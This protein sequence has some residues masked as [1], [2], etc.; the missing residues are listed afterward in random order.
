MTSIHTYCLID[1]NQKTHEAFV[2]PTHVRKEP[3]HNAYQTL[4]S[5]KDIL[6]GKITE[7]YTTDLMASE[8]KYLHI[9]KDKPLSD[10]E[11]INLTQ[12]SANEV[13][14]GYKKACAK[15]ASSGFFGKLGM[16]IVSKWPWSEKNSVTLMHKE[17]MAKLDLIQ[18]SDKATLEERVEEPK[19]TKSEYVD[20]IL[21]LKGKKKLKIEEEKPNLVIKTKKLKDGSQDFASKTKKFEEKR[22][23]EW[24]QLNQFNPFSSGTKKDKSVNKEETIKLEDSKETTITSTKKLGTTDVLVGKSSAFLE[25]TRELRRKEAE[26]YAKMSGIEKLWVDIF[27]Y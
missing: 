23:A 14:N 16:W 18:K 17:I 19:E 1:V 21:P 15:Q 3:R 22:K 6:D 13:Y 2:D 25:N 4:K 20:R 12:K 5:L 8:G 26:A 9:T 10:R 24:E 11:I 27:G 7:V